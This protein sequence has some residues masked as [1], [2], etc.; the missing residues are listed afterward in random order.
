MSVVFMKY[1][2]FS[3]V[4]ATGSGPP[5]TP[6]HPVRAIKEVSPGP[7]P[8]V[9]KRHSLTTIPL[10]V[11]SPASALQRRSLDSNTDPD[12]LAIGGQT[13]SVST[14]S[15]ITM[16]TE[17]PVAKAAQPLV[18]AGQPAFVPPRN[19]ETGLFVDISN[20]FVF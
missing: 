10:T 8:V 7:A 9:N 14:P 20:E 17:L 2:F 12:I 5:V 15:T 16:M 11:S 18:P 1:I 3:T 13:C 4:T 6:A 19:I